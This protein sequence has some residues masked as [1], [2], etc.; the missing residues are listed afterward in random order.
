LIFDQSNDTDEQ[1]LVMSR[2]LF[3][4]YDWPRLS[5]YAVFFVEKSKNTYFVEKHAHLMKNKPHPISQFLKK[6]WTF[7]GKSLL[8]NFLDWT[9]MGLKLAGLVILFALVRYI[10]LELRKDNYAIQSFQVP[11]HLE[12]SG[13]TGTVLAQ[14]IMDEVAIIKNSTTIK[15]DSVKFDAALKPDI[16]MSV[17]GIGFSLE[18]VFYYARRIMGKKERSVSGDLTH[19]GNEMELTLRFS[20][21]P[22]IRVTNYEVNLPVEKR[23]KKL[24]G[25]A[26]E[27]ILRWSDPYRLATFYYT[28][29][30]D[31]ESLNV[32]RMMLKKRPNDHKWAYLAW[33]NLL[34]KQKDYG[35][36]VE[37]YKKAIEIDPNFIA[38]LR[39]VAWSYYS[40]KNYKKALPYFEKLVAMETEPDKLASIWEGA[41]A[42]YFYQKNNKKTAEA[43]EKSIQTD[44]KN[45]DRYVNYAGFKLSVQKDTAGAMKLLDQAQKSVPESAETYMILA[46][47]TYLKKDMKKVLSLVNKA[48]EM[49]PDNYVALQYAMSIEFYIKEYD[50]TT[51]T[52]RKILLLGSKDPKSQESIYYRQMAYNYMAMSAY[53]QSRY[54]TALVLIN[55]GIAIDTNTASNY[56]TLAETYMLMKRREDFY[57]NVSKAVKKGFKYDPKIFENEVYKPLA[58]DAR[59][60]KI[61]GLKAE[62]EKKKE[63]K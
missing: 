17:M 63:G 1:P 33:G 2:G 28:K 27:K 12:E 31:E 47:M 51:Q 49:D 52:G 53:S 46:T 10:F 30:R 48:L 61:T 5:K 15:S 50:Q 7:R 21:A 24:M 3:A 60:L 54:D 13:L 11:K 37:K 42:C 14:K 43:Y 25:G 36:A 4:F 18:T 59:F 38:P 6:I 8:Q 23:V 40:D 45:L 56:T 26:A 16:D 9:T 20:D 29:N 44:P 39:N 32:A 19:I 41:A 62:V 58:K 35:G 22:K 57:R 34:R 55:K